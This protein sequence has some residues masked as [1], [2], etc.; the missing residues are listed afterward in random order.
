MYLHS[1]DDVTAFEMIPLF[2]WVESEK[3]ES[4]ISM[5]Q[6]YTSDDARQ[7]TVA[8]R[9]CIFHD[10]VDLKY[11]NRDSY[12]LSLCMVKCRMQKAL[13][14]CNCV[15]PYYAPFGENLQSKGCK[16]TIENIQCISKNLKNITSISGC[17]HCE[18]SCDTTIYETEKF[19]YRYDNE[20]S[21]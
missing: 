5:R 3:V 11:Y 7:L 8:Q 16:A 21:R 10:E 15:P 1:P 14:L 6:T 20:K 9:K 4:L 17:S 13:K 12:S 2:D 19:T 18:L